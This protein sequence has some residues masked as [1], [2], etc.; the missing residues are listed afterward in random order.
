M[1]E[2]LAMSSNAGSGNVGLRSSAGYVGLKNFGTTC[3][4]N[5]LIQ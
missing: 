4:M 3:Y 2:F 1:N 5:S